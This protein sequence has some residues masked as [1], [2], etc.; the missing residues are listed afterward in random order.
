MEAQI[1]Q[2]R[3]EHV[4]TAPGIHDVR[5]RTRIADFL[6]NHYND[7]MNP[8]P[9]WHFA[10]SVTSV[11]YLGFMVSSAV[12]N[13]TQTLIMTWPQLGL[14]FGDVKA[15]TALMKASAD[16]TTYYKRGS[17]EGQ[18][19]GHFKMLDFLIKRGDVTESMA[20]EL[21]GLAA[22]NALDSYM[23]FSDSAHRGWLAFADKAMLIFKLVEQWNRRVTARAAYDLAVADPNN[24]AVQDVKNEFF[25]QYQKMIA[26]GFGTE[27]EILAT[28]FAGKAIDMSHYDYSKEARPRFMRGRKGIL[29]AFYMFTQNTVFQ[30][31]HRENR[32]LF[33]RYALIMMLL[34]GPMGL[35][36]DEGE[37]IL[38]FVARRFFGKDFNLQ[39]EARKLVNDL[40]NDPKWTDGILHGTGRYS[41]GIPHMLELIGGPNVPEIDFSRLVELRNIAPLPV[42]RGLAWFDQPVKPE[43]EMSKFVQELAGA[44][45]G[46]PFNLTMA[47]LDNELAISDPKRWERALPRAAK[48]TSE[49]FRRAHEGGERVGSNN[50]IMQYDRNDPQDVAELVAGALGFTTTRQAHQWDVSMAQRE[51]STF[52]KAQRQALLNAAF[53]AKFYYR[54]SES[55]KRARE[56]I[57]DFNKRVPDPKLRIGADTLKKSFHTRRTRQREFLQESGPGIPPRIGRDVA[58]EF[59][60]VRRVGE[61]KVNTVRMPE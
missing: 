24:K 59:P 61:Q 10:R 21:A 52:W 32:G 6:Q 17:Y 36:P 50:Y 34:A 7:I 29:F 42:T 44:G 18:S 4:Q 22:G 15:S 14:R 1:K 51:V 38:N 48:K 12:L 60:D 19:E 3:A 53:Q 56:D 23:G 27:T 39:L 54:D 58:R 40:T 57:Q 43:K 33:V 2:L 31:A 30:L 8:Q 46:I 45:I 16:L 41:F 28:L 37:D 11:W 26:E 49:A 35:L 20:A 5:K 47:L 13:M 9:D 55:W 25:L